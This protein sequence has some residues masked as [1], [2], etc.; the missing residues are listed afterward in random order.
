MLIPLS[1]LAGHPDLLGSKLGRD[2][3]TKL[4]DVIIERPA[5]RAFALSAKGIR[6]TDVTFARD[7]VIA[8]AR[9]HRGHRSFCLVDI[10]DQDQ[11]DNWSC[12]ADNQGQPLMAWSG[13]RCVVLGSQLT[14]ASRKVV[15]F[16]LARSTVSVSEVAIHLDISVP[17]ASTTLKR[18]KE[19]GYMVRTEERAPTG[20]IEYFYHSIAPTKLM[21]SVESSHR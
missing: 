17:N 7:S 10:S 14:L 9:Q 3:F 5:E 21:S 11:L 19:Q 13:D 6:M 20:G 15:D 16:V 18:L 12:A 1:S 4:Q 8:L 2:V